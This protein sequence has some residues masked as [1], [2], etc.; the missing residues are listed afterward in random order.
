MD[1]SIEN[2]IHSL[3]ERAKELSCLYRVDEILGPP[4]ADLS[5][6]AHQLIEAIPPGWQF[7]EIC[8]ARLVLHGVVHAP[9]GF[10]PTPWV[11][12]APILALGEPV[13]DLEVYYLQEKPATDEGPFL[14]EERKLIQAIADRIGLFLVQ[15][16]VRSAHQSLEDAVQ[17]IS[18]H[19]RAEWT[20]VIDLLRRTDPRLLARITRKMINH[21]CSLGV[22]EASEVL[23]RMTTEDAVPGADENQP[24]QRSELGDQS[25]FVETAF[26]MAAARFSEAELVETLRTWLEEDKSV[27]LINALENPYGGLTTIAEAIA[28]FEGAGV[29]E[30]H[31]PL[32]VRR[33]LRVALVRRIFSDEFAFLAVAKDHVRVSDFYDIFSHMIHPSQSHGKLGGK[34]TGLFLAWQVIQKSAPQVEVLGKIRVPRTW[35]LTSD[36]L[37]HFMHYNN[38]EDLYDRKYQEIE[39]IRQEY[40]HVVQVFKNSRFPPDIVKGLAVVLD[41]FEDRPLIVRSSSLLEDRVGSAFSGKYKSLFLANQGSK[42]QRLNALQ[43]A[44]AEVYA[45]VFG[46]DPIEYRAQKGLLDVHEEMAILVQEVVG[47]RAGKYFLPAFAGVAF[48]NNEFRWSERIRR[49]DGLVRMVPGLG[50]RAVDRIADD[51]P[52]LLAPGQAGLR[53]NVSADEI[54]HYAPRKMDVIDLEQNS[55]VTV[56]VQTLLEECGEELPA[57]RQMVSIIDHDRIRPPTMLEPDWDRD[58]CVVTFQGLV[59]QTP[60][61][62]QMRQLLSLLRLQ[63]GTPVDIEFACD[64]KNFYLLQ[65]RAQSYSETYAPSPIPRHIPRERLVFSANRFISNGRVPELTH[66]VYVVPERYAKLADVRDMQDIGR[67]VGRLNKVLPRRQFALM[68]P[69]RWGSRG[70]IRL[71]VP[72]TYS[73]INNA[74]ILIEIA[75]KSGSYS[76]ELSFGTHFFQDLVEADIRYIPLYPDEA[77][78][79]FHEEFLT[80]STN[81][82]AEIAPELARLQDTVRVIDVPRECPGEVLRVLMNADL[83]EAVGILSPPQRAPDGKPWERFSTDP[84]SEDSERWHLRL[85]ERIAANVDPSRFGVQAM[86]L[87]GAPRVGSAD[88]MRRLQL[89]VHVRGTPRQRE[90]LTL[91]LDGWSRSLAAM[92]ATRLGPEAEGLLDVQFLTDAEIAQKTPLAA[93]LEANA[94]AVTLGRATAFR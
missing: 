91:W 5:K 39:R 82:L 88:P 3:R 65:C 76:P 27:H 30:A 60:F 45:S 22:K 89:V 75:R 94:R 29:V 2:L 57:L 15:Q 14:R 92:N 58:H 64:G 18:A 17:E 86:Y 24:L 73:D 13:G 28:R 78:V 61:M 44:I 48:S 1:H 42:Q 6:V 23:R 36:T 53:V 43:D 12:S 20:I 52:V 93:E 68:G 26:S 87:L 71:G 70:D 31:L 56:E 21:L 34:S 62:S 74:A 46:P 40:P 19:E 16:R 49:E 77:E 67:A 37:L 69:G 72:V 25:E 90:D 81:I 84:Y 63:L 79:V 47:Q 10:V 8:R 11:Q 33:S 50:T 59:D 54:I 41:E 51:Y 4:D 55:L 7:P 32:A 9:P 35:Y 80:R 38:L 66:I 83:D 85:A